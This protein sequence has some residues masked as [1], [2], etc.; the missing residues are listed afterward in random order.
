MTMAKDGSPESGYV[1][2]PRA[3]GRTGFEDGMVWMVAYTDGS[4]HHPTSFW[5]RRSTWSLYLG[6]GNS[7]NVSGVLCGPDQSTYRAEVRAILEVV[8]RAVYHVLIVSDCF[9]ACQQVQLI[10]DGTWWRQ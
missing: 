7:S 8:R 9:S 2:D 4:T 6:D 10:L 1:Y 3:F 5:R